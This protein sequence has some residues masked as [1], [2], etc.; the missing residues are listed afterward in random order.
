[1]CEE[2][3]WF[4]ASGKGR[5]GTWVTFH[6][7]FQAHFADKLPYVVGLVDLEEGPRLAANIVETSADA[8]EIGLN[9][10][11]VFEQLTDEVTLPQFRPSKVGPG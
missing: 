3:T 4:A 10:E 6:Q 5:L 1:L 8:L 9:V 7:A 2:T 11:V